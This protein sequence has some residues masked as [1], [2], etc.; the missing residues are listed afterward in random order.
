MP[1]VQGDTAATQKP[2]AS[3]SP[4]RRKARENGRQVA[5][6]PWSCTCAPYIATFHTN[7]GPAAI[8]MLHHIGCDRPRPQRRAVVLRSPTIPPESLR[9][10]LERR[11][12]AA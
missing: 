8:V 3:L 9:R 11:G 7:R 2:V 5:H 4:P 12:S 1:G 10:P 6:P